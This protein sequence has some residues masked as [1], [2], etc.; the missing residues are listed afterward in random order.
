MKRY[1]L[2]VLR[3]TSQDQNKAGPAVSIQYQHNVP[4]LYMDMPTCWIPKTHQWPH[5]PCAMHQPAYCRAVNPNPEP[6]WSA[7]HRGLCAFVMRLLAPVWEGKIVTASS[8]G[9]G[10]LQCRLSYE[11]LAV[12]LGM[13]C[14]TCCAFCVEP[15]MF[16]CGLGCKPHRLQHQGSRSRLLHSHNQRWN[17]SP[18]HV[19]LHH[20]M[21][22]VGRSRGSLHL[23]D[24]VA[25]HATAAFIMKHRPT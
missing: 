14:S 3:W 9:D 24:T 6:D 7:V 21:R 10:L 23:V 22:W 15:G 25:H 1:E 12:R 16:Q 2:A 5:A 17:P 18:P 19:N 11:T 13:A 4:V 20:V 8:N